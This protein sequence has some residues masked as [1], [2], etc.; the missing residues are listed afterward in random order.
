MIYRCLNDLAPRS[1][2]FCITRLMEMKYNMEFKDKVSIITLATTDDY[3]MASSFLPA[4]Q[5]VGRQQQ[6]KKTR[7]LPIRGN[8][9]DTT[10]SNRNFRK[11]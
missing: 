7:I 4:I 8:G 2:G 9:Y 6:Q 11:K 5:P 1:R 3:T 10:G